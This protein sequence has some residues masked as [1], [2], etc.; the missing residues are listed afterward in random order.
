[1]S[2]TTQQRADAEKLINRNPHRDFKAVEAS[3]SPWDASRSWN[4]TQTV[5]P[6]W[7]LGSGANDNGESLK[8]PHIE[9]DP[10]EEG[11]PAV[12][13]YKLMISSIIPRPI[14][15]VSTRSADG[16]STNLAPFSYFN[17][18]N[19]DPPLF[20]L[21]YTGGLDNAKDSL[22]NLKETGECTINI[23]SEHFIEAANSTSINAPYGESEWAFSGLTPAPCTTV[24]TSRVLESH[25]SVEGKL[26]SLKEFESK[27]T[28][29]KKTGVLAI[30]EGT[31]FWV[32]E[33]AINEEKNI[34]DP[35]VLKPISRLG[36]I[37]YGRTVDGAEIP[38]P[39][40]DTAVGK[41]EEAKKLV[42]P[43]LEDQ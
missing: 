8:V 6:S 38:R 29:G 11:R 19:H 24:K 37:T 32:R 36:G 10:Y 25:F 26:E 2:S 9:I 22:R 3:R 12:Y 1:M 18:I 43:K 17:M 16:K 35:A 30:I 14:G 15:F 40:Y 20:T 41:D 34:V 23:I 4:V 13:N 27:A 5:S 7:K 39:D 42:K 31:R 33:N 28:P 21:G